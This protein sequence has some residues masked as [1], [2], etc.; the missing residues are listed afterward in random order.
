MK[1]GGGETQRSFMQKATHCLKWADKKTLDGSG[2]WRTGNPK[3]PKNRRYR[4][5]RPPRGERHVALT[6]LCRGRCVGICFAAISRCYSETLVWL[7]S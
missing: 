5:R 3:P 7:T 6:G 1:R 4:L 2:R